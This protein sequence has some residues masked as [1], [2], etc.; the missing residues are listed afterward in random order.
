VEDGFGL[1]VG[2]RGDMAIVTVVG[3]LDPRASQQFP[4]CLNGLFA[5]GYAVV[6]IDL[7]GVTYIDSGAL[8]ALVGANKLAQAHGGR[9]ILLKPSGG[10]QRMLDL[11]GV[12]TLVAVLP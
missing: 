10:V 8:D 4:D 9:L 1:K 6:I 11:T 7:S 12:S 2:L 5:L 3:E